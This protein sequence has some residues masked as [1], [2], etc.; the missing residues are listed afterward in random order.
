MPASQTALTLPPGT[1]VTHVHLPSKAELTHAVKHAKQSTHSTAAAV[2]SAAPASLAGMPRTAARTLSSAKGGNG[3]LAV[4]GHGLGA[5]VVIEHS[6]SGRS[7]ADSHSSSSML[8][9]VRINGARGSMLQTTLG[10]IVTFDRGA[11]QYVVI[12][13]RPAS[14]ILAA[15]RALR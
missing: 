13:A 14:T 1:H 8:P 3:L 11:R 15:A 10:T 6:T 4:Y 9:S 5:V 12:G 7:Q 2:T